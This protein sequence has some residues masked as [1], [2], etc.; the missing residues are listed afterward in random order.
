MSHLCRGLAC[1]QGER[2]VSEAQAVLPSGW[3]QW[4]LAE[5]RGRVL[6]R[7]CCCVSTPE[8]AILPESF[9]WPL[10]YS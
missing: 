2:G 8:P 3:E 10:L 9:V 7:V 6:A 5:Q 1:G 4:V